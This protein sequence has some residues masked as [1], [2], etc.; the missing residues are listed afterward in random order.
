MSWN[1]IIHI[2]CTARLIGICVEWIVRVVTIVTIESTLHKLF[3]NKVLR[4]SWC[5][6]KLVCLFLSCLNFFLTVPI[7]TLQATPGLTEIRSMESFR[8]LVML[9]QVGSALAPTIDCFTRPGAIQVV[10]EL[11]AQLEDDCRRIREMEINE[12]LFTV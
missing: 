7:G 12:E 8:S 9:T 1:S 11:P 10:H 6:I 2:K 5:L 3:S 4:S